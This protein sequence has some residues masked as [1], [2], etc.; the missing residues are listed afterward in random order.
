MVYVWYQALIFL[1]IVY[2]QTA[3]SGLDAPFVGMAVL[4][5]YDCVL[6]MPDSL[7]TWSLQVMLDDALS[8]V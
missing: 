4:P 7:F 6:T 8:S 2:K 1:L 3:A 5:A